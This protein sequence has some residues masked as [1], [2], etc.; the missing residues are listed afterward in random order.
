MLSALAVFVGAHL[1]HL[2]VQRFALFNI[3]LVVLWL[4][5]VTA[6]GREY[7]KMTE[8]KNPVARV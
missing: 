8:A 6:I 4:A 7:K 3:I 5:L 1:M 2:A